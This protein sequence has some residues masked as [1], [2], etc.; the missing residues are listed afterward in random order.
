LGG[1]GTLAGPALGAASIVFLKNFV[2][3][4]TKRW[5]LILGAVY[6]GVILFAP[7]GVLGAFRRDHA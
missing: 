3:V 4:Y 1:P 6:I 7:R 5:L 2:S